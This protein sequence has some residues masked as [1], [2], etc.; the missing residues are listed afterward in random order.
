M[1]ENRQQIESQ[2]RFYVDRLAGLIG[3]RVLQKPKSIQA[4]LGYL[5]GQCV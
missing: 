2:L 4:A 3:P 1:N 5:Q